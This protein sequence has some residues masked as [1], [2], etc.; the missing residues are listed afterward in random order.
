VLPAYTAKLDH[1]SY[2][3]E[4]KENTEAPLAVWECLLP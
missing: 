2:L 1:I 4:E 3:Y